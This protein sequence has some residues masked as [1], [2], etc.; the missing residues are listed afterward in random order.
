MHRT[1]HLAPRPGPTV[2]RWQSSVAKLLSP[3]EGGEETARGTRQW[4]RRL[5]CSPAR[6][7]F[8]SRHLPT[9]GTLIIY[10]TAYYAY[11]PKVVTRQCPGVESNC[12]SELPQD[13]KSGTLP[14][15]SHT[16]WA[17]LIALNFHWL[18]APR[19]G[20]ALPQCMPLSMQ[21]LLQ[22]SRP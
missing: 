2:Y 8:S 18:K 1:L 14:L 9:V 3:E 13:Y 16:T 7:Q 20:W 17:S 15:P 6:W 19:R 5:R 4:R 12:A 11:L 22:D 21:G 10:K